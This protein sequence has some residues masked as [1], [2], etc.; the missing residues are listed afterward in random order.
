MQ[1]ALGP[2]APCNH[3]PLKRLTGAGI[4]FALTIPLLESYS[5]GTFPQCTK[6]VPSYAKSREL[7]KCPSERAGV[8][9]WWDVRSLYKKE[10]KL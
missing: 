6:D 7:P 9:V 4:S 3:R 5:P 8:T 10:I 2:L 1:P